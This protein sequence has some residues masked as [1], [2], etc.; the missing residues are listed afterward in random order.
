[1]SELIKK[2]ERKVLRAFRASKNYSIPVKSNGMIS[3]LQRHRKRNKIS[4]KNKMISIFF[5]NLSRKSFLFDFFCES[6]FS[7]FR[8]CAA[9]GKTKCSLKTVKGLDVLGKFE[10]MPLNSPSCG[11]FD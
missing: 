10:C 4:K 2:E 5:L 3:N 7:A 11:F 9:R 1:M 6:R 8:N